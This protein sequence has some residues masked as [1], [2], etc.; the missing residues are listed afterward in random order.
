MNKFVV[1]LTTALAFGQNWRCQNGAWTDAPPPN[2]E[3]QRQEI[4]LLER[5]AARAIQLH[6]RTFFRRVY[7]DDF[8]GVLSHGQPV[9]K[10]HLTEIVQSP[11][12]PYESFTASDIKVRLYQDMAVATCVWSWR[13]N[14]KG[15]QVN[16]A[17]RVVHVYLNTTGGWKVVAGQTTQLPPTVTQPL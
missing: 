6:D 17:M 11:T 9:D 2:P 15:Q 3:M 13:A 4:T 12:V 8:S 10:T 14:I 16:S 5:E 7:S 1:L